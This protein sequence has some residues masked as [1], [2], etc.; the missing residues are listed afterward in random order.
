MLSGITVNALP[1]FQKKCNILLMSSDFLDKTACTAR[2]DT[3][4]T[5]S[6]HRCVHVAVNFV[7]V[8]YICSL[9]G[10]DNFVF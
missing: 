7:S 10:L 6:K 2:S 3:K 8:N 9:V 5:K 4:L 1:L